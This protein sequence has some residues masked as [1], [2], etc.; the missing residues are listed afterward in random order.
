[1]GPTANFKGTISLDCVFKP[2]KK[3][4]RGR[5]SQAKYVVAQW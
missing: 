5:S 1:M 4:L 2:F 3:D